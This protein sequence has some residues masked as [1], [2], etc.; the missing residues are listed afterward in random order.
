VPRAWSVQRGHDEAE[1]VEA[2]LREALPYAT[3]FT[4]LEPIEDPRSYDDTQPHR[5]DAA[6]GT[7]HG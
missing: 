3:I 5:D 1:R 2:A 7:R 6:T 4:R